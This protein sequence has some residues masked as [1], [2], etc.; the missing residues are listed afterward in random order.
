MTHDTE[1]FEG[2][3]VEV[4]RLPKEPKSS[5]FEQYLQYLLQYYRRLDPAWVIHAATWIAHGNTSI[6]HLYTTSLVLYYCL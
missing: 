4:A 5:V 3:V 6:H 1:V 2:V